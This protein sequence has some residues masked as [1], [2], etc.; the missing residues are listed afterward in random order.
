MLK[1]QS[2]NDNNNKF[3]YGPYMCNG[4]ALTIEQTFYINSLEGV[5]SLSDIRVVYGNIVFRPA[6]TFQS[7]IEKKIGKTLVSSGGLLYE[8]KNWD[9]GGVDYL[10]STQKGVELPSQEELMSRGLQP[11]EK[12]MVVLAT[13]DSASKDDLNSFAECFKQNK[14]I[15][16][17]QETSTASRK[18]PFYLW[19]TEAY[20]IR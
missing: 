8:E 13:M 2:K 3:S 10:S 9:H 17:D 16:Y 11:I 6:Y 12:G 4:K 1:E 15:I 20:L 18:P 7:A 19:Y 5:S 14:K